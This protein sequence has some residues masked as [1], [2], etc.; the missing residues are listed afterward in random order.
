MKSSRVAVSVAALALVA[1]CGTP[2]GGTAFEVNG[3]DVAMQQVEDSAAACA[4][5][6]EQQPAV[7]RGEIGRMLLAGELADQLART[8]GVEVTPAMQ[9]ASLDKL[10]GRPLLADPEC[11]KAIT[12]FANYAA[13]S[14]K[15]GATK[16]A[17]GLGKLDV[18]VNP[19][20][21]AWDASRGTFT[22]GSG[23]LS[24]EDLSQGKVLGAGA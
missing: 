23:S 14:E 9:G 18:R 5:L 8:S 12:G 11:G 2:S 6:I 4:K 17:D 10:Q 1:G 15:L 22:G 24:M 16:L 20:F 3:S 19:A 13:V 21:G 7:I